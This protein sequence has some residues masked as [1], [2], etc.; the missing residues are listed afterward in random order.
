MSLSDEQRAVLIRERGEPK[1]SLEFDVFNDGQVS[2][3]THFNHAD[4]FNGVKE[5]LKAIHTHLTEF[6]KDEKMCPFYGLNKNERR[7]INNL[8]ELV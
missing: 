7:Q 8:E 4:N 6:L 5:S 1:L 3:W 2:M